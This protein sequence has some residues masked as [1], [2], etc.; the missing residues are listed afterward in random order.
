[1]CNMS[2]NIGQNLQTITITKRNARVLL[3]L[4]TST[5]NNTKINSNTDVKTKQVVRPL[6]KSKPRKSLDL[7]LIKGEGQRNLPFLGLVT[8]RLNNSY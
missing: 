8:K 7:D 6:V 3:R 5:K 4:A 1:M 2:P